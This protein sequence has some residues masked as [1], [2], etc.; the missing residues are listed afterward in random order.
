MQSESGTNSPLFEISAERSTDDDVLTRHAVRP[1]ETLL[2]GI[3]GIDLRDV[4]R[5]KV[6]AFAIF[7]QA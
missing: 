6:D 5:H 3:K 1:F 2:E 4:V 7:G